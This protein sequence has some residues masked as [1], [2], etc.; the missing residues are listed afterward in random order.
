M[1]DEDLFHCPNCDRQIRMVKPPVRSEVVAE[2][3]AW[4]CRWCDT[5]VCIYCYLEH[6]KEKHGRGSG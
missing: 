4:V 2:N 6:T 5:Y 3:E 1:F